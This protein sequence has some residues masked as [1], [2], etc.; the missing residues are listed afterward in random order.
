M[1]LMAF[2]LAVTEAICPSLPSYASTPSRNKGIITERM[3]VA[4]LASTPAK[5]ILPNT[6]TNAA[7]AAD[8]SA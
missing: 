2:L 8:R 5:P 1:K 4:V 7:M 6:A 3:A